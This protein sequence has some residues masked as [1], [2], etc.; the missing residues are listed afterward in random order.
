MEILVSPDDSGFIICDAPV[1]LVPPKDNQ[2][3]GFVIPGVVKYFPISR[4]MCFRA[5]D[6]GTVRRY[7]DVGRE[8]V[9]IINHNIA[10]NSERFIMGPHKK[11][12][13]AV[14]TRSASED[15]E[16]IPR[17]VV[18]ALRSDGDGSLLKISSRP[19]RYFYPKNG[20]N[21]AP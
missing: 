6:R 17:F 3:V 16:N 15:A 10:A 2:Q 7:R 9:R 4:S 14:V 8:T 13:E 21:T 20:S 5:G 1:T 11:Q 12:L 18:E 19:R